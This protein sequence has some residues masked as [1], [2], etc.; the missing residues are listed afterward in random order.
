MESIAGN[1]SNVTVQNSTCYIN[2]VGGGHYCMFYSCWT[3]FMFLWCLGNMEGCNCHCQV[4]NL[5]IEVGSQPSQ[6]WGLYYTDMFMC[7]SMGGA[8]SII[9]TVLVTRTF[10]KQTVSSPIIDEHCMVSHQRP[11]LYCMLPCTDSPTARPLH[12]W[13]HPFPALCGWRW[14]VAW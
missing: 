9:A 5:R 1:S 11:T 14:L 13:P 10:K 2:Q 4:G 6:V 12:C 7:C 8:L 3:A